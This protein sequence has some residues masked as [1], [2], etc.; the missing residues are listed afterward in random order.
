MINDY[1]QE[2]FRRICEIAVFIRNIIMINS[3]VSFECM[4]IHC[5]MIG[6]R[7]SVKNTSSSSIKEPTTDA[8]V[9]NKARC[10][11]AR[12]AGLL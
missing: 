9:A 7:V 1:V 5:P 11:K 6:L 4:A 10:E 8:R 2:Q 3:H 12:I